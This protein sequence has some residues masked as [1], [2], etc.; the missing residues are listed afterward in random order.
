[1]SDVIRRTADDD[2]KR[3][4]T[5]FWDAYYAMRKEFLKTGGGMEM[6]LQIRDAAAEA[7]FKRRSAAAKKGAAK[8]RK[9]G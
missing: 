6:Q 3:L 4:S 1:M 5:A 2:L 8:R 7:K 9:Y